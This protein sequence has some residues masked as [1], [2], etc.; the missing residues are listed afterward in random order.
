MDIKLNAKYFN[1]VD[2]D[3]RFFGT[4]HR[5]RVFTAVAGKPTEL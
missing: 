5:R 3:T 4:G 1:Q 2:N